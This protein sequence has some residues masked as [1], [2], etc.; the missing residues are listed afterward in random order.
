MK[1]RRASLAITLALTLTACGGTG[2]TPSPTTPPT[3][4]PTPPTTPPPT[5]EVLTG[6]WYGTTITEQFET[7]ATTFEFI[8]NGSQV[9]GTLTLIGNYADSTEIT[10][11]VASSAVT[12]SAP[13]IFT[14]G[15]GNDRDLEYRYEGDISE[16]TLA[17]T[18]TLF[19]DGV[20]SE[21]GTFSVTQQTA[22]TPPTTPVSLKAQTPG[23]ASLNE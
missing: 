8:Q 19:I 9:S 3:M 23:T 21:R 15:D 20:Q 16:E 7:E 4:P 17:G 11:A 18:V 13:F 22:S 1:R 10:G 2:P 5:E 6:T 12:I 14:D